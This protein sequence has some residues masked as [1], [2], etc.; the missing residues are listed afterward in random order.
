[1]PDLKRVFFASAA[2]VLLAAIA[3][4]QPAS[5]IRQ[6][7]MPPEIVPQPE[8]PPHL[9][10]DLDNAQLRVARYRLEPREIIN[11]AAGSRGALV[12]AL[13]DLSLR[14]SSS[15]P[16]TGAPLSGALTM[17][18]GETRWITPQAWINNAA[19]SRCEFLLIEPKRN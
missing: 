10:V 13:T 12:V 11:V 3:G 14:M 9:S 4:G 8:S 5:P 17:R 19:S 16:T 6:P 7:R 1:M 18:A 2:A 15:A